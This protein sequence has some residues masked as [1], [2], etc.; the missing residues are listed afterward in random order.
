MTL[1]VPIVESNA[2]PIWPDHKEDARRIVRN[3]L[4]DILEW[5]GEKVGPKPGEPTMVMLVDGV[6]HIAPGYKERL[7]AA[8]RERFEEAMSG[9]RPEDPDERAQWKRERFLNLY[10]AGPRHLLG[11]RTGRF[12]VTTPSLEEVERATSFWNRYRAES[13]TAMQVRRPETEMGSSDE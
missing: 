5:L 7:L 2:L 13:L 4:A 8:N 9:P 3:G 12:Q 10:G 6:I 1:G 11:T